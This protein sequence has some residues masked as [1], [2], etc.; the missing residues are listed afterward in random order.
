MRANNRNQ[1]LTRPTPHRFDPDKRA[2][3][4]GR[5]QR[6]FSQWGRTY[7]RGFRAVAPTLGTW[8]RGIRGSVEQAVLEGHE[9]LRN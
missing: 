6:A 9:L 7:A 1:N 5:A 4:A 8:R 3:V 2:G